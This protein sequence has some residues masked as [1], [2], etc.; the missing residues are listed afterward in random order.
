MP[1]ICDDQTKEVAE[2]SLSDSLRPKKSLALS[3]EEQLKPKKSE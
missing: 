3:S 2:T 1:V